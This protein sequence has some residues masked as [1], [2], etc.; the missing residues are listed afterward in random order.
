MHGAAVSDSCRKLVAGRSCLGW[1]QTK[2][3]KPLSLP[4]DA[5]SLQKVVIKS[6]FFPHVFPF[7]FFPSQPAALYVLAP[8]S[9]VTVFHSIVL[10]FSCKLHFVNKQKVLKVGLQASC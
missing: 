1:Y 10:A 7:L 6:F 9:S 3:F 5:P 2:F 8:P 4:V